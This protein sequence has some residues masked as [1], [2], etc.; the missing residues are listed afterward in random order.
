M[1]YTTIEVNVYS[2]Y[3]ASSCQYPINERHRR[4]RLRID[5]SLCCRGSVCSYHV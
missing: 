5:S 1:Q 3:D 2:V 4:I